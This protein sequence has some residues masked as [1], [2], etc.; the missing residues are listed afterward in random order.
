M[1]SAENRQNSLSEGL[2]VAGLLEDEDTVE[3]LAF[4]S[5]APTSFFQSSSD[6]TRTPLPET[7]LSNPIT[8]TPESMSTALQHAQPAV[9]RTLTSTLLNPPTIPPRTPMVIKASNKKKPYSYRPPQGRRHV[10]SIAVLVLMLV[11]TGGTLLAVSPLGRE[12]GLG[13]NPAPT[14]IPS[15][16]SDDSNGGLKLVSQQA[17]ATAVVHQQ[18]D[19]FDPNATGTGAVVTGSPSSWPVGVCTYWAN[20]RYHELTGIWVTWIGNAYQWADGARQ[21]GWNVSTSPHIPSIVVLMPGVQG[22]SG[23]G[24]VAVAEKLVNSTTVSTSNMNWFTNGGGF[25]I[26]SY[27]NFSAGPGVYFIWK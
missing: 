27:Y 23:Y 11:I 26:V 1:S 5:E 9:T 10:I 14:S 7:N 4:P 21:A 2:K 24:H 22:A 20:A 16:L 3:Q 13:F 15:Y 19:G 18:N 25:N 12:L 17:T 8:P 6:L